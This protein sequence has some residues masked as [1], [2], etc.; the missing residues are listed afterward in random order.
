VVVV[1]DNLE[2]MD[3]DDAGAGAD[4]A[5]VLCSQQPVVCSHNMLPRST[6]CM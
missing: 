2:L 4:A 6:S 5:P 1:S 3:Y